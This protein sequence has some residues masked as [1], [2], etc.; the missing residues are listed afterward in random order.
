MVI[1]VVFW[2]VALAFMVDLLTKVQLTY[3]LLAYGVFAGACCY[4]LVTLP[5]SEK[6][7]LPHV[8]LIVALGSSLAYFSQDSWGFTI[9][10]L[11]TLLSAG[12]LSYSCI[13]CLGYALILTLPALVVFAVV[14]SLIEL[15]Q[16]TFPKTSSLGTAP[17][18][19]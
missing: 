18:V 12:H 19:K 9:G 14:R 15:F 5:M 17:A 6:A 8:A 2:T 4:R 10:K 3:V 11:A 7:S 13:K 1:F 16:R